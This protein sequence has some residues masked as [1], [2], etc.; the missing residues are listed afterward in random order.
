MGAVTTHRE[1]G[2]ST[3]EFFQRELADG[4]EIL[5]S[6][7]VD[8]IFYAAVRGLRCSGEAGGTWAMAYPIWRSRGYHNFGYKWQDEFDGPNAAR[9]PA[10]VLD[11]LSEIPPCTHGDDITY[12][13]ACAARAWRQRCRE[14]A[15]RQETAA[16]MQAGTSIRLA[17]EVEFRTGH[18]GTDYELLDVRKGHVRGADGRVYSL[19]SDWFTRAFEVIPAS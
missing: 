8:G 1:R 13:G 16:A 4:S 19:G 12:C 15:A 14:M 7:V 3:R 9:C 18:K 5:A 17:R 2:I 10:R 11:K 6:A